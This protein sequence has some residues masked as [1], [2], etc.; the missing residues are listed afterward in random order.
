MS[1][2]RLNRTAVEKGCPPT[3]EEAQIASKSAL[4]RVGRLVKR[5][6]THQPLKVLQRERFLA[7]QVGKRLDHLRDLLEHAE[8]AKDGIRD[9]LKECGP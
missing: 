4:E 6:M 1:G 8:V 7:G 2:E 9:A 5:G 3:S